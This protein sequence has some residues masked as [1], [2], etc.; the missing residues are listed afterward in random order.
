MKSLALLTA[1]GLSGTAAAA[2]DTP[3]PLAPMSFWA[4]HCFKGDFPDGKRSDE[5]CFAWVFEGKVLR[6]RHV[7]RTPGQ[8]DYV[9]ET[10][11]VWD[12]T[13]GR[14]TYLYY[15]NAGGISVG[16]ATP[17]ADGM[18]FPP[19]SYAAPGE[20]SLTYRARWTRQG[21]DAYEAFSEAQNGEQWVPMWKM[22]LK[23]QP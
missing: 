17:T 21:S 11:Y 3:P 6:D 10:V 14:I 2:A 9:G 1:I 7:V 16:V 18:D 5:H 12:S 15:E 20:K 23:A 19:A 22:V 4:G 8:P 13:V